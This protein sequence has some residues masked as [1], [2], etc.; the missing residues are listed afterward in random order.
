MNEG[1]QPQSRTQWDAPPKAPPKI[2][3]EPIVEVLT[4]REMEILQMVAR[5]M[6]NQ[7]IAD[8]LV[9]AERTVRTHVS[10]ILSKLNLHNRTQATLVALDSGLAHGR[11]VHTYLYR[12]GD[13]EPPTQEGAYWM[14]IAEPLQRDLILLAQ[15]PWGEWRMR[16]SSGD[17]EPYRPHH[18]RMLRARFWGPMPTPEEWE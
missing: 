12:N 2:S 16:R 1:M 8:V 17:W 15:A 7:A 5:G 13:P 11:I 9:I 4:E 14:E 18:L 6:T 3:P 10:N